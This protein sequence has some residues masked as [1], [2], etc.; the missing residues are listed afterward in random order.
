MLP[1]GSL[2]KSLHF[3]SGNQLEVSNVV[4]QDRVAQLESRCADQEIS[5]G[6]CQA[7]A[8]EAPIDPSRAD[9]DWYRDRLDGDFIEQFMKK[10][11][12]SG[13]ARGRISAFDG[14]C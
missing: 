4:C 13:P 9:G 7:L 11:L 6:N 10:P 3:E 5:Q 14:M 8:S 1:A 2:G 12:A